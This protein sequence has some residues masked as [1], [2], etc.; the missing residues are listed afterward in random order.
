MHSSASGVYDITDVCSTDDD[1][2]TPVQSTLQARCD[3]DTD[4]GEWTVILRRRKDFFSHVKF[5]KIG[6]AMKTAS[7][8]S[9]LSFG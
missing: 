4:G 7:E 9:I 1:G 3:M 5:E 6:T 2:E 8:I